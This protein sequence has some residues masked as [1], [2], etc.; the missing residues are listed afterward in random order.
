MLKCRRP[1]VRRTRPSAGHV[2]KRMTPW[3]PANPPSGRRVQS[4]LPRAFSPSRMSARHHAIR[5]R[6]SRR[7]S[8]HRQYGL[9]FAHGLLAQRIRKRLRR[10]PG[11]RLR[12]HRRFAMRVA[13]LRQRLSDLR[14][15]L[16]GRALRGD[17]G[18]LIAPR[19]RHRVGQRN[20]R[21]SPTRRVPMHGSHAMHLGNLR[22]GR[23]SR[24]LRASVDRTSV[25]T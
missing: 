4:S 6:R 18:M 12:L 15:H 24:H 20:V 23:R 5:R 25:R 22:H 7:E 19:V 14:T 17:F 21:I 16:Y 3:L 13:H 11:N 8:M 1:P 2:S 10:T 9:H